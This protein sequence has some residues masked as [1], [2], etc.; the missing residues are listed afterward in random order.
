MRANAY[1]FK[2]VLIIMLAQ[3][4]IISSLWA[5]SPQKMSY[6]AVIRNSGGALVVNQGV[7][8][9]ISIMQG[10]PSGTLTYQEV[11]S[12]NPLTNSN[13]LVTIE[14]GG[15]IPLTG[16]FSTIDWSSGPYFLKTETDPTGG[17]NYT[18]TGTSQLLSVPYALYSKSAETTTETDPVFGSWDKSTGITITESQITDFQNYLT[19]EAQNLADVI[20]INNSANAQIKNL[21]DPTDPH[22]AVTKAYIDAIEARITI[23]E[24]TFHAGGT[25]TDHD[26]NLYNTV[27]IGTMIWMTENL[28]T[29]TYNN[30][31]PI[32]KVTNYS[33]WENLN[34]GAYCWFNNDSTGFE[35]TYGKLYNWYAVNTGVLCPTG[36]HV[37]SDAEWTTLTTYLGGELVAGDKLKEAGT[38]HW[39]S[40]NT[41]STNESGFT[42]LPGGQ[43]TRFGDFDGEGSVGIFWSATQDDLNRAISRGVASGRSEVHNYSEYIKSGLSVRCLKDN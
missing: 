13:G 11:F 18:I 39:H 26:G 7:G 28:R 1:K 40:P 6:Q 30:G 42:V 17:T 5:Q 36:W 31:N 4:L 27:R 21:T 20:A 14:I 33:T 35:S 19:T 34:T 2:V 24:N 43:R 22:D 12:P 32:T 8:M 29:S 16:A 3:L 15:G 37:P 9:K 38:K 25:V 10:S 41:G 23:M